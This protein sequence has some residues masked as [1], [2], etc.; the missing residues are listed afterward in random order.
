M[1]KL[2]KKIQQIIKENAQINT[3]KCKQKLIKENTS[4]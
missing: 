1:H 4:N 2:I 3:R